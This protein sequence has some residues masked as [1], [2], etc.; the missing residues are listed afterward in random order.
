MG[1]ALLTRGVAGGA[2]RMVLGNG[3]GNVS[4]RC[5]RQSHNI[6]LD[7]SVFVD[8]SFAC[9]FIN[10]LIGSGNVGR[11]VRTF[12][13]LCRQCSKVH[14]LLINSFSSGL[15]P[16]RRGACRLVRG[17]RTVSF[18]NFRRSMHPY[19]TTTSILAFP[20]CQRKFPGMILRTKTV[21]LP[22]VI[23]SVDNYG[24]VVRSKIGKGVVGPGS[25]ALLC[26]AVG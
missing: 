25:R 11:L 15:S 24:R 9:V 14:L 26:R 23:A 19:F 7:T 20:D 5:F 8:S 4:V 21:K 10:H 3:V 2:L 17:R 18:I 13:E 16:L 6:V 22:T 1:Q 12:I